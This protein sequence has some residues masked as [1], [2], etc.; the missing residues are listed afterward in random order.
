MVVLDPP[1][2]TPL[3]AVSAASLTLGSC[4]IVTS[5]NLGFFRSWSL[6]PLC[7]VPCS[8]GCG[9]GVRGGEILQ[10]H[11]PKHRWSLC[12]N[13]IWLLVRSSLRSSTGVG[14]ALQVSLL[15]VSPV[16]PVGPFWR[17]PQ[18]PFLFSVN[19]CHVTVGVFGRLSSKPPGSGVGQGVKGS[20]SVAFVQGVCYR[21]PS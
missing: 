7:A 11:L 4:G 19:T 17:L 3:A 5:R 1:P 6:V 10:V 14:V 8:L 15:H 16:N 18:G 12:C 13:G 9:V 20:W 21:E 2:L